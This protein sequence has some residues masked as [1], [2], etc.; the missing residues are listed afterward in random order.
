MSGE[1]EELEIRKKDANGL[2][3]AGRV[4]EASV[5]Y[6]EIVT[7]IDGME[8]SQD[9]PATLVQLSCLN[10]LAMAYLKLGRNQ[11][12]IDTCTKALEMDGTNLK[13]Y[14]RRS[15]SYMELAKSEDADKRYPKSQNEE[16]VASEYWDKADADANSILVAESENKQGMNLKADI[17]KSKLDLE[18]KSKYNL[19][20]SGLAADTK[21]S[22]YKGFPGEVPYPK[23]VPAVSEKDI[24]NHIQKQQKEEQERVAAAN[25][26][27]FQKQQAESYAKTTGYVFLDPN[28][29]PE[30]AT[31]ASSENPSVGASKNDT[32]GSTSVSSTA[33][34]SGKKSSSFKDILRKAK[35]G[36]AEG[37]KAEKKG[38]NTPGGQ[39]GDKKLVETEAVKGALDDLKSMEDVAKERVISTYT[40]KDVIGST[41]AKGSEQ[42]KERLGFKDVA[43]ANSRVK[44]ND[45]GKER[46]SSELK[47]VG[48]CSGVWA[49]LKK[50]EELALER[51]TK[52]VHDRNLV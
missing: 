14:Y 18:T 48:Q 10:N 26:E 28:W 20:T 1:V 12:C 38:S 6:F 29:T 24:T 36:K 45:Q 52:L 31:A 47:D 30:A 50:E 35:D 32:L 9:S 34:K 2:M 13:A 46:A 33:V 40:M 51:V 21:N 16:W 8:R 25:L 27:E 19:K 39:G 23:E 49:E 4:E 42:V 22:V 3:A 15:L 7:S 41:R 17:R 11:E 44:A 43:K 5:L 37:R